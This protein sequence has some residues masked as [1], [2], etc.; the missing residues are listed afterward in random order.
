MIA[1]PETDLQVRNKKKAGN[2]LLFVMGSPHQDWL[3]TYK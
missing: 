1:F 2:R 3:N